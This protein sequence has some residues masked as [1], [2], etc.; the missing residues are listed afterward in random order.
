MGV[1][2]GQPG[3][4]AFAGPWITVYDSYRGVASSRPLSTQE[5]GA[6]IAATTLIAGPAML[7]GRAGIFGSTKL[8]HILWKARF[9]SV[10]FI[11]RGGPDVYP[12]ST[13]F[14]L[15]WSDPR[16]RGYGPSRP[17]LGRAHHLYL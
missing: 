13:E 14:L 11:G 6:I 8:A 3:S 12:T 16:L 17:S 9:V 7:L 1:T 10:P 2:P 15:D 4:S 5:K